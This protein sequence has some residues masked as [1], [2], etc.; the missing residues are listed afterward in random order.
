M[1]KNTGTHGVEDI[2]ARPLQKLSDFLLLFSFGCAISVKCNVHWVKAIL[3]PDSEMVIILGDSM[4]R[5]LGEVKNDA[6][7]TPAPV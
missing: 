2:L 6:A 7:T 1:S 4:P 3:V 5:S